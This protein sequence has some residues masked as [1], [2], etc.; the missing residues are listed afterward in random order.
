MVVDL[1]EL[2][3]DAEQNYRDGTNRSA[4]IEGI[5]RS[6]SVRIGASWEFGLR[7]AGVE[8]TE[9]I[10]DAWADAASEAWK[11]Y[12]DSEKVNSD[13]RSYSFRSNASSGRWKRN[14]ERRWGD[15]SSWDV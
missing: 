12:R 15:A 10:G 2:N 14:W 5:R 3:P 4:W 7:R 11:N 6:S 8:N 13:G 9:G 1:D